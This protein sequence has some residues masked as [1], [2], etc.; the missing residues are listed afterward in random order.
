MNAPKLNLKQGVQSSR[1]R[2]SHVLIS[3]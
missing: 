1:C 2:S 3:E